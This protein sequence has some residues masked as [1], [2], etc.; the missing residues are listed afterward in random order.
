MEKKLQLSPHRAI[1]EYFDSMLLETRHIDGGKTDTA[2]I[3]YGE[4]FFSPVMI[5]IPSMGDCDNT[6]ET[7]PKGETAFEDQ[8]IARG[9]AAARAGAAVWAQMDEKEEFLKIIATGAKTLALLKPYADNEIIID[10][11]ESAAEWGAF[12]IGMEIDCVFGWDGNPGRA[13][14]H[15]LAPKTMEELGQ[16]VKA[17]PLPFVVKGI[18]SQRDAYKCLEAGAAGLMVS[19][20]KV[21]ASSGI[22]PL[23]AL[24]EILKVTNGQIPVFV[25]GGILGGADVFKCLAAGAAAV[26]VGQ[27]LNN[28]FKQKGAEGVFEE[29]CRINAELKGIMARTGCSFLKCIGDM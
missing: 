6:T 23:A 25:E 22:P 15:E 21:L 16:L 2:M 17:S 28:P 9:K 7:V 19:P 26:C 27:I 14:G 13:G 3:L 18:L 29:I 8:I 10:Q 11:M 4:R 12:A 5:R 1:R 24:P 20:D